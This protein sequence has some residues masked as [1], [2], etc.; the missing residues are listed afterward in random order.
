MKPNWCPCLS[1]RFVLSLHPPRQSLEKCCIS[2]S[3]PTSPKLKW[4]RTSKTHGSSPSYHPSQHPILSSFS[5]IFSP[6]FSPYAFLRLLEFTTLETST[7]LQLLS[8]FF[9]FHIHLINILI[10][11]V[12]SF[13]LIQSFIEMSFNSTLT[14]VFLDKSLLGS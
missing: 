6:H 4:K 5:P 10:Y 8:H 1:C 3:P 9:L 11:G 14:P 13:T 2:P 12:S 7:L